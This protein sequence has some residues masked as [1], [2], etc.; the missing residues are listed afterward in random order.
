LKGGDGYRKQIIRKWF[1]WEFIFNPKKEHTMSKKLL[2]INF[3]FNV[4]GEAYTQA[5]TPLADN[6]ASVPGLHWKVW[7]INE[8]QSEAGGILLFNDGDA[9]NSY[10]TGD[11]AAG[12]VNHPALSDFSVKT[13]DIMEEQTAITR[14]P[15][16][17]PAAA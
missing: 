6:I 2:Q 11:I 3:K 4:T 12:I 13:F 8:E 9:L 15:L 14:G 10:L 7:I 17:Q 5:V 1:S 16:K